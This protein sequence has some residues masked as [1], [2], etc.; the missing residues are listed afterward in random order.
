MDNI[1]DFKSP[2]EKKDS[3]ENQ[4]KSFIK[5]EKCGGYRFIDVYLLRKVTPI[6]DPELQ[7]DAIVPILLYECVKCGSIVDPM[8]PAKK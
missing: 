4:L 1:I 5:C 8:H 6:E 2:N 7:Q 3:N